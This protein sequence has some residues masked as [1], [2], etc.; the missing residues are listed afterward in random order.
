[1]ACGVALWK[2]AKG[3]LPCFI[4]GEK[5]EKIY[6]LLASVSVLL[7]FDFFVGTVMEERCIAL[8]FVCHV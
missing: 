1:M 3:S 6:I 8:F 4:S 5:G 7:F 2:L